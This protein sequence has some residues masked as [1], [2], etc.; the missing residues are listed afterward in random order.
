MSRPKRP[1]TRRPRRV[2]SR[3]NLSTVRAPCVHSNCKRV[4]AVAK[5]AILKANQD[6]YSRIECQQ[7]IDYLPLLC[8]TPGKWPPQNMSHRLGHLT[9]TIFVAA[10]EDLGVTGLNGQRYSGYA[11]VRAQLIAAADARQAQPGSPTTPPTDSSAEKLHCD[12]LQRE[13]LAGVTMTFN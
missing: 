6:G 13:W 4:I 3:D 7:A 9:F 11:R 10:C 2:T 8:C 12:V 5:V 1:K